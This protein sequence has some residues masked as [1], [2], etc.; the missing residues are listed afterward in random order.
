MRFNRGA[1]VRFHPAYASVR[2]HLLLE[3]RQ[4]CR[5]NFTRLSSGCLFHRRSYGRGAGVGRVRGL[6][7]DLGVVVTL[8]VVVGVAEGV[9]V[10][11][12]V[13]AGVFVGVDTG[14]PVGV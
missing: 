14:V 1:N 13:P 6:G 9:A 7:R 5:D 2:K 10:G 4:G 8:G 12:T 3:A 11:V